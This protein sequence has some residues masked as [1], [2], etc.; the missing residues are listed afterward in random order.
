V[1]AIVYHQY[2]PPEV[3]RCADV[4]KPAPKDSEV[5]VRVR[6]ASINPLDWHLMRGEPWLLRL[7]A[8]LRRPRMT[9]FGIDLAGQVEAAGRNA[10]RFKPGDEVFGTARGALAE[11]VCGPESALALRPVGTTPEEAAC[12]PI[13]ALTALQGL[14]DKGRIQPGQRVLINGAAG[15]VGTFAVQIAKAHATEVTG[16][17]SAQNVALVRSLGADRVIDYSQEDF[18]AGG[19]RY[20]LIVD[21]IGNHS[22]SALRRALNPKGICVLVGGPP[23][24]WIAPMGRMIKASILSLFIRQKLVMFL[25]RRNPEALETLSGLLAAGKITSV[26]DRRFPLGETPAAIRYL[27]TGHARGKVVIT[28]NGSAAT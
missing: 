15:G 1:Q 12:V 23:G 7:A 17:C 20:D 8:G 4:A 13:A 27:E 11:Y 22:L 18:T 3:L 28:V 19:P 6:A 24:K 16:V 2:G 5:L 14:R 9:R 21:M 25:A 26:V 10:S